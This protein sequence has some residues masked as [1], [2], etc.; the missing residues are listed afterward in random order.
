MTPGVHLQRHKATTRRQQQEDRMTT[1]YKSFRISF[2]PQ[3]AAAA[4]AGVDNNN[5]PPPGAA[6]SIKSQS[7]SVTSNHD[8][9]DDATISAMVTEESMAMARKETRAI[10][11]LR[12]AVML[13]LL[14]ATA[15]V[16][17]GIYWYT[18]KEEVGNFT[19]SF[20]GSAKQVVESFVDAVER[21]LGAAA[22]LSTSITSY[23]ALQQQLQQQQEN[24]TTS[25]GFPFVT[26]P[27]FEMLGSH[28]RF[29]SGSHAVHWMPIVHDHQREAWEAYTQEHRSQID[30]AFVKD[31]YYRETQDAEI[32]QAPPP[33]SRQ[34]QLQQPQGNAA[35]TAA[36]EEEAA[37][38]P[39]RNM[40]IVTDGTG[41]HAR[42]WS[43]G[44]IVPE[45]DEPEHAG[46]FLPLWQRSPIDGAKQAVLNMNF[47]QTRALQKGLLQTMMQD[48]S[49]M[50]NNAAMPIPQIR[51]RMVANLRVS[52][53]REHI[54]DYVDGPSTFLA[55]PVFDNFH[56]NDKQVVGVLGSNIYWKILFSNLLP[57]NSHGVVCVVENSFN[58]T[59]AYQIDGAEA[60]FLG[61]G[62]PHD[63]KYNHLEVSMDLIEYIQQRASPKTRA[64]ATAP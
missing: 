18:R 8:G 27:D 40:S 24:S 6:M 9:A 14:V 16:S 43:N 44:A 56:A 25:T 15:L 62:D 59:F 35:I 60:T 47:A 63:H 4:E 41:F 7:G 28:F 55:Y 36:E 12:I 52:Q 34:R 23:A 49:A 50:L 58:Q 13:V 17:S 46:P 26:L 20:Q 48:K 32:G 22:S 31:A 19:T 57:P 39:P 54:E 2:H 42:I 30:D 38:A 51:D 10:V 37:S 29:L 3:S 64:Y 21:Q 1:K 5:N 45:G 11:V 33:P 53:Y 61:D